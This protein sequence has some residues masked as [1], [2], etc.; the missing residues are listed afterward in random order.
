MDLGLKD[1][2]VVISGAT[3]GI[4]KAIVKAFADEGSKLVISSTKQEKL[5]AL[6]P[7]LGIDEDHV[8]G[9]ACDVTNE[10][11]VKNFIDGATEPFGTIDVV[12]PNAG[13]EGAHTP[14]QDSDTAEF[15]RVYT[16]NIFGPMYMIKYATPYLL[17]Q[18]HGAIVVLASDGSFI[19]APGMSAYVSSKHV[20]AGLVKSVSMELGPHGIHCNYIC[21]GAVDTPMMRRIEKKTFGD[22]KTP[23]E[24]E[25]IFAD[26]YLDKR[27]CKPEEVAACALYLASDVSV[28]M[29]SEGLRLDAGPGSTSR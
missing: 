19:A 23:E 28:H 9:F 16:T 6:I 14:I 15:Q 4:G 2:V 3:G 12:V 10:E 21:P 24:A 13:Y 25:R 1:K 8:K 22:T 29:M 17:K 7:T 20:V 11:S 26:A 5:D 27:Y 18:E